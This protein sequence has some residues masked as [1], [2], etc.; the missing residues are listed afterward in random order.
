MQK[1]RKKT[2]PSDFEQSHL[3]AQPHFCEFM[4]A[5]S[6]TKSSAAERFWKKSWQ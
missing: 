3:Q 4:Y 6:K 1:F 5:F 2:L